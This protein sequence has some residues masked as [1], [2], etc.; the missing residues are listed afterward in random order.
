MLTIYKYR[1]QITDRQ[2]LV[3]PPGEI[4]SAQMQ[5]GSLCVWVL[6]NVSSTQK[7]EHTIEIFGTGNPI[8][9]GNRKFIATVQTMGG[10][11]VWHIFERL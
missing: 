7:H 8:P 4:L 10:S 1:L 5:G 3:T 6:V 11:L 2:I 9:E